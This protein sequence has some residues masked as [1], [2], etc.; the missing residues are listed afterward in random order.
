MVAR[1]ATLCVLLLAVACGDDAPEPPPPEG[2][3]EA[4]VRE[5]W[6]HSTPAEG[7]QRQLLEGPQPSLADALRRIDAVERDETAKGLFLRVG[8]LEGAWGRVADVRAA[9]ARV[10]AADKPVHC[11]FDVTDNAGYALMASSCDR[12]SMTPAG[13]LELTG[14]AAH[15]FFAKTLLDNIGVQAELMQMGRYKGAAEPFT[16]ESMSDATRESIGALLDD[17]QSSLV[18]SVAE[19]RNLSP[20][21]VREIVDAAPYGAWRAKEAGL[22]DDV[23]FDDEAREHARRAAS[24]ERVTHVELGD[25]REPMS[26]LDLLAAL[27]GEPPESAP[28]GERIALVYLEG[29]IVDA[30]EEGVGSGRSG[31][32]VRAMRRIADDE[33]VKAVVLRI[34]SPGGSALASDR[35]WHAVRR[36]ARRKPVIVSVGDMAA[37]GGYYIASA[38][39][40]ILAHEE[41]IVGSIGVVGGKVVA[42]DLLER[43]GVHVEILARGDNAAWWTPARPFD[44]RERAIVSRMLRTI[45]RRFVS[46]VMEGR[47]M[48]RAEVEAAAE[49]RIH[50]G[51]RA[52]ELGLI[53]DFGGLSEAVARARELGGVSRWAP[54]ERWPRDKTLLESMAQAFGG[55]G[56]SAGAI[57]LVRQIAAEL[58]PI[59]EAAL[60]APLLLGRERVAVAMPFVLHVE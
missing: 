42:R 51:R 35:M 58:G 32:F 48:E 53:D 34:D 9:L 8:A 45:Y 24:V 4:E 31:P 1:A 6:L 29:N 20:E 7:T 3:G 37:S 47:E 18:A 59:G 5:L 16:R 60:A 21:R 17:L 2:S 57:D 41:S 49:G 33:E 36:V 14:V 28:E 39:T 55:G 12:I 11:H 38:G 50:S 26:I 43:I 46:R 22:V 19:G 15:L 40:E 52:K 56:A 25:R 44:D 27:G 13:H 23:A 54:I 30:E 10:R